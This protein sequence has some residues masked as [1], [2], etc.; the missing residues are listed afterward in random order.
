V[1]GGSIAANVA[2]AIE[3][4][5]GEAGMEQKKVKLMLEFRLIKVKLQ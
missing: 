3:K 2:E 1:G 4:K 5:G